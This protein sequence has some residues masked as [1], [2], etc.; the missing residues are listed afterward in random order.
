MTELLKQMREMNAR[1]GTEDNT[2]VV[3]RGV[4]LDDMT[5]EELFEVVIYLGRAHHTLTEDNDRLR[6]ESFMGMFR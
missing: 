4:R 5:K 1:V 2:V 3:F 6:R